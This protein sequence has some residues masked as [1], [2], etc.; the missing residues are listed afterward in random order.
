MIVSGTPDENRMKRS[1]G[2]LKGI[3]LLENEYAAKTPATDAMAVEI[4]ARTTLLKRECR[5]LPVSTLR[6]FTSEK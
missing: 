4:T 2:P 5:R 3:F 6:K 1:S